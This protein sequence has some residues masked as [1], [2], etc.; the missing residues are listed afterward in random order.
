MSEAQK[1]QISY[2]YY[3][4]P[5]GELVQTLDGN[6][7]V[8]VYGTYAE[9]LHFHN[10][11]E[12]GHCRWGSGYMVMDDE[13]IDY[14]DGAVTVVPANFLHT[15]MS[16]DRSLNSWAYLFCDPEV[17]LKRAYPNDPLFVGSVLH[18]LSA[19]GKC[20]PAEKSSELTALISMIFEEHASDNPYRKIV[21]QT[22][23][24]SLLLAAAQ[25]CEEPRNAL[26]PRNGGLQHIMPAI[27]H[28]RL[29][30]MDPVSGETLAAVCSLSEAQLRRKFREY[31]SMSPGEYLS[32][33]RIEQACELLNS[34]GYSMTE[35]AL[36]VGYRDVSSFN[37]IFKK[38]MNTSPYQY[39]KNNAE[40]RGRVLNKKITAKKGQKRPEDP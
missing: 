3:E 28:I 29:H 39:K 1:P 17:I 24:A 13:R 20:F 35:V 9:D 6:N 12:I 40:Y 22:L 27:E 5:E 33:V 14:T 4:L 21:T 23:M 19:K 18:R 36:R 15:T 7:W 8:C 37:R 30:Y 26:K 25:M 31:L 10:L 34:T 38:L 16:R 2:R 11:M 32:L